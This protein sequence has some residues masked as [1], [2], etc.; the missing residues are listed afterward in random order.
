VSLYASNWTVRSLLWRG[1]KA[2][3]I[4]SIDQRRGRMIWFD[5]EIMKGLSGL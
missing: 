4:D 5:G 1:S 2:D 3:V